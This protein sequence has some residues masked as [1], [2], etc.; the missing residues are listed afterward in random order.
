MEKVSVIIP[1]YD[2][3]STLRRC[4]DSV[5]AQDHKNWELWLVDDGSTDRSGDICREYAQLDLRIHY[6][7]SDHSGPSAARNLGLGNCTG[8]YLCFMDAD[9]YARKDYFSKLLQPFRGFQIQLTFSG[10]YEISAPGRR[11]KPFHDLEELKPYDVVD[12]SLV[13]TRLLHGTAGLICGKM[14]LMN[15]IRIHNVRFKCNLRLQEDLIFALEYAN[16]IDRV[17]VINDSL[18]YYDRSNIHSLSSRRDDRFLTDS[19][20]AANYLRELYLDGDITELLRH[21]RRSALLSYL[22]AIAVR[23]QP[24][25]R[26]MVTLKQLCVEHAS[27]LH[28]FPGDSFVTRTAISLLHNRNWLLYIISCQLLLKLR[29]AR[30]VSRS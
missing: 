2:A 8:D 23:G 18:Y 3:A 28:T 16:H 19:F 5:L 30:G 17:A 24:L 26:K 9:D 7:T 20:L 25:R 27:N 1:V 13:R 11:P 10:Y 29:H 6:L 12:A 21:R 4:I 15:V 22:E 14:F